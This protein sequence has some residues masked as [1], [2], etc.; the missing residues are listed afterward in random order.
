MS[1]GLSPGLGPMGRGRLGQVEGFAGG[2]NSDLDFGGEAGGEAAE[3]FGRAEGRVGALVDRAEGAPVDRD[4]QLR[5]QEARCFGGSG[6]VEVAGAELRA[7]AGDRDQGGV[8][9]FAPDLRN[10]VEEVGVAGE[11]DAAGAGDNEAER[12]RVDPEGAAAAVVLRGVATI[13]D[14]ARPEPGRPARPPAPA[15]TAGTGATSRAARS[16]AP[17]RGIGAATACRGDPSAGAR[18]GSRRPGRAPPEAERSAADEPP[19]SEGPGR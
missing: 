11:V 2:E 14:R 9:A 3:V 15:R 7:P 19:A 5:V 6:G 10:P 12:G 1:R 4:R 13:S 18:R 8:E 17:T 16:P